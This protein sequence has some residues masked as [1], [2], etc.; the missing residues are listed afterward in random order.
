VVAIT[1]PTAAAAAAENRGG[2]LGV[3]ACVRAQDDAGSY[4]REL[5]IY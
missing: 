4:P 3:R 5:L 1:T 2:S